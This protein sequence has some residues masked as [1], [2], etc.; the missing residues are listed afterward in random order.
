MF[1]LFGLAHPWAAP[2]LAPVLSPVALLSSAVA[3]S[4]ALRAR[5]V[6]DARSASQMAGLLGLG[7]GNAVLH[8]ALSGEP[9]QTTNLGL[10]AMATGLLLRSKPWAAAL[11]VTTALSYAAVAIRHWGPLWA[12]FGFV[13]LSSLMLAGLV[14]HVRSLLLGRL[15]SMYG[16][17][18]ARDEALDAVLEL[19]RDD[20][21]RYRQ[22]IAQLPD[23]FVLVRDGTVILANAAFAR[24]LGVRTAEG[25]VGRTW[26]SLAAPGE[27]GR[28]ATMPGSSDVVRTSTRMVR[29]DG[30]VIDVGLTIG[31]APAAEATSW[32][33]LVRDETP[34][35]RLE[36]QKASFVSAVHHELLTPLAA[37]S[38]AVRMLRAGAAGPVGD[39]AAE[40]LQLT[41]RN[42]D[43]LQQLLSRLLEI[44]RLDT[45][46][47]PRETELVRLEGIVRTAVRAHEQVAAER[48]VK[49]RLVGR[50]AAS[51]R[52]NADLFVRALHQLL[53]NA[54]RFSPGGGLVRVELSSDE[55]YGRVNVIDDGPGVPASFEDRLF[56]RF[57]QGDGSDDRAHGGVGMGLYFVR[58]V[59]AAHGGEVSYTRA[60]DKTRFALTIPLAQAA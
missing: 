30:I 4:V 59:V 14:F 56:T 49:L 8:L 34:Q 50:T 55:T 15:V 1:G 25:L 40:L 41:S 19:A 52:L 42:A 21:R 53:S 54:V 47:T 20:E 45:D 39:D 10:V 27:G 36:A 17:V 3:A 51:A 6:P 7:L 9:H 38:G 37:I 18:R 2:S 60:G 44:Q 29:A 22:L 26:S 35:R 12:H 31:A 13:L 24:L 11:L 58:A 43:R 33:V 48:G 23:G 16:T 28:W 5:R 32:Q 46:G 57:S